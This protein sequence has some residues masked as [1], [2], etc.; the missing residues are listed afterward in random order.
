VGGYYLFRPTGLAALPEQSV[1]GAGGFRASIGAK[2]T[3]T[4]GLEIRNAADVPL[5][6]RRGENR[7][8]GR[9][10]QHR[11]HRGP[12]VRRTRDHSRR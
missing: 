9:S 5:D 10:D 1:G 12:T 4:V 2:N 3:I 11:D 6:D 8:P 7:S